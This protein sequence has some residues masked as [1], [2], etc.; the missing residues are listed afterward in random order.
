MIQIHSLST[1][2]TI[3]IV[4]MRKGMMLLIAAVALC[5]CNKNKFTPKTA[6]LYCG[7]S[8]QVSMKNEPTAQL[9]SSVPF[10]ASV[11]ANG[12]VKANHVGEAKISVDAYRTTYSGNGVKK[13]DITTN[14]YCLVTVKPRHEHYVEPLTDWNMT[15]ED[16]MDKLGTPTEMQVEFGDGTLLYGNPETDKYVTYY[17]IEDYQLAWSVIMTDQLTENELRD[18]LNERYFTDSYEDEIGDKLNEYFYYNSDVEDEINMVVQLDHDKVENYCEVVYY[19]YEVI[20][21]PEGKPAFRHLR[22]K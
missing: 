6:T 2:L 19:K 15:K 22:N 4:L 9:V 1:C 11:G 3:K 21:F 13:T 12:W 16:I 8:V 18:F 17:L 20:D 10:V 14:D 7:D 5:A